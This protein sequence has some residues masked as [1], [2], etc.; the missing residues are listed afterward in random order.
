MWPRATTSTRAA[1]T[2]GLVGLVAL[3]GALAAAPAAAQSLSLDP[4]TARAAARA[5]TGLVSDDT[6]AVWWQNPAGAARREATRVTGGFLSVD[7]DLEIAPDESNSSVLHSRAGSG[8]SPQLSFVTAWGGT[9]LGV[10]LLSSQR[11]ARRFEGPPPGLSREGANRLFSM[12]YAGLAGVIRRDTLNV[13][14]ARRL[15]DSLAVGISLG[16]SRV[17]VRETRTIWAG[18]AG[19]T[20]ADPQL[21]LDLSLESFDPLVPT[22]SAGAVLA[23]EDSQLELAFGASL[24]GRSYLEGDVRAPRSA[25]GTALSSFGARRVSLEIPG[26]LVLRTGVRWQGE[27]WSLEGNG[28][29]EWTPAGARQLTWQLE[30]VT[31]HHPGGA[32]AAMRSLPAQLSMRSL[33]TLRAAGDY[34]VVEGLLW[35]CGGAGWSPIT[36]AAERLSPGF[37]E[38]GGTTASIGAEVSAGG[39]TV[40]LGLSR[41]WTA[42]VAA[43]GSLHRLDNPFD[44]GDAE[45]GLGTYRGAV[46]LVGVSVEVEVR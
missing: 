22:A 37:S 2:C 17:A 9:S 15:T 39:V 36:T 28:Q 25:I 16:G 38:L 6:A 14:A 40:A 31:F 44:G 29:L 30:G 11:Q 42:E 8:F 24:M 32:T 7:T 35:L 12:R 20:L 33:A 18:V 4:M 1:L 5:G 45:T 3:T 10:S 34:E 41:T 19:E 23:P 27:R 46:D 43:H 26:T 13:G 21:D